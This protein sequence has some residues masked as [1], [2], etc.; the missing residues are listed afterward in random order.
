MVRCYCHKHPT[1][2]DAGTCCWN[3]QQYGS[4]KVVILLPTNV[5]KMISGF[6]HNVDE[7]CTL[8]GYYAIISQNS[9]VLKCYKTKCAECNMKLNSAGM[10]AILLLVVTSKLHN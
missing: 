1:P 3:A 9:T 2:P 10:S 8:L 4:Q 5:T 7:I 6:C